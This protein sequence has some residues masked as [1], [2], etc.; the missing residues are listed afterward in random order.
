MQIQTAPSTRQ[1]VTYRD[2]LRFRSEVERA[3]DHLGRVGSMA[4]A[5]GYHRA[6]KRAEQA[7]KIWRASVSPLHADRIIRLERMAVGWKRDYGELGERAAKWISEHRE[8]LAASEELAVKTFDGMR[9]HLARRI[10]AR[11]RGEAV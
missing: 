3:L 1:Q 2:V 9:K 8:E 4:A 5:S 6:R 11:A 10:H 7:E